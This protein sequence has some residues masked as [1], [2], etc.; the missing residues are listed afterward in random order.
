MSLDKY[1]SVIQ[2]NNNFNSPSISQ[3]SRKFTKVSTA[4]GVAVS[5]R[6]PGEKLWAG[7]R[8][9]A[10]KGANTLLAQEAVSH[11]ILYTRADILRKDE[12]R[13]IQHFLQYWKTPRHSVKET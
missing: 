7:A 4:A 12:A 2:V 6:V 5:E 11:V 13:E 3:Y 10:I 9:K 1:K 8:G